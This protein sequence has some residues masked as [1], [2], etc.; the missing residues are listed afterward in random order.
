MPN[1]NFSHPAQPNSVN[2]HF[3]HMTTALFPFFFLFFFFQVIKFTI[4]MFTYITHFDQKLGTYKKTKLFQFTS[5]KEPYAI[6]AGSDRSFQPY[7]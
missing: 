3:Y 4:G 6:L 7:L 5:H 1:I 2:K